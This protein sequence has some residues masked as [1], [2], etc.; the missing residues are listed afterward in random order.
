MLLH[1]S[2]LAL[3][4]CLG[5]IY[6]KRIRLQK[7]SPILE[8]EKVNEVKSTIMPWL[9]L[10]ALLTFYA[11]V[12]YDVNDTLVYRHVFD[13][14]SPSWDNIN[15]IINDNSKD[16]GFYILQ[17]L[18]KMYISTDF[19]M[20]FLFVASIESIILISVFR[21]RAV[22]FIDSMFFF[23]C[24]TLYYNYFSMMRQWL[25]VCI[26]FAG[27]RFIEKKKFIPY[28][29]IC[30]FAAQFH[31]S[32]IIMIIMYFIV[33]GTPFGKKHLTFS[34][35]FAIAL[36]LLKPILNSVD[37]LTQSGTYDYVVDS[38]SSGNGSSIIRPVIAIVPVVLVLIVKNKTIGKDRTIDICISFSLINFMLNLLAVFTSGIYVVRLATYINMYNVILYPYLLNVAF[39]NHE[40]EKIIKIGFYVFFFAFYLYQM[41]YS[42]SFPYYSDIIG[43]WR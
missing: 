26:V 39:K 22:S 41:I 30:L 23:F 13:I 16:K 17:N 21:R 29:L 5:L 18:F 35:L 2:I 1:F 11:A 32:A 19:H 7:L 40:N 3:I 9:L 28:A 4:L 6:E 37:N 24:S 15:N 34:F 31:N 12:R 8:G 25:A 36:L 43:Y 33:Q 42:G 14:L 20:W 38:M 27:I 10:F